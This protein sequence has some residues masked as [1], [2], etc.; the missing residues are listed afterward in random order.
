MTTDPAEQSTRSPLGRALLHL[1]LAGV[2]GVIALVACGPFVVASSLGG[3]GAVLLALAIVAAVV[4]GLAVGLD[5]VAGPGSLGRAGSVV[6]GLTVGLLGTVGVAALAWVVLRQDMGAGLPI[7]LRVAPAA[8]PFAALAGLQWPGAVRI[9]TALAVIAAG[10][11]V[12]V[13]RTVDAAR[14]NRTASIVTEVGT[15]AHPWVTEVDGYDAETPQVTGS[16]LIWST[17]RRADGSPEPALH[18]FRDGGTTLA[19]DGDPCVFLGWWTPDGDQPT[20]SCTA[21]GEQRWHRT[22]EGWQQL[23]ERRDGE[24]VG[25]AG[26]L[27]APAPLLEQALMNARPM[28]DDEYDAWIEEVFTSGPGRSSPGW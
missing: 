27:D 19:I 7:P 23:L 13:P 28:T 3:S 5:R 22:S 1:L 4:S 9:V 14:E 17:Y 12:A 25:V 10:A 8:L 11:V 26:P 18:L 15:T 20:T 2:L 24:W 21:I 6:R 16:E